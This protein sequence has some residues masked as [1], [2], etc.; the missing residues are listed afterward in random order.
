MSMQLTLQAGWKYT[1]KRR[2]KDLFTTTYTV[3]LM[4]Q[5]LNGAQLSN[6]VTINKASIKK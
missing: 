2:L 4:E 3:Q 5:G 6:K 1:H